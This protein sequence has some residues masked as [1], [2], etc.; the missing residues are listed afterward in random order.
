MTTTSN[1]GNPFKVLK[2]LNNRMILTKTHS[3]KSLELMSIPIKN[4]N[5]EKSI[6]AFLKRQENRRN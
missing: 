4:G 1:P 6:D 5:I 2:V 3:K